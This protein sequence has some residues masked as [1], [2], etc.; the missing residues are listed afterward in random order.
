MKIFFDT[1]VYIAEALLGETAELLIQ[2]TIDAGWRISVSTY[3][4]DEF[5]RVA[6][7][8]LGFRRRFAILSRR[9]MV[10]RA[11]LI[12][13]PASRHA[14]PDDP[15]DSPILQAALAAGSDYLV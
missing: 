1:N 15:K 5:E 6:I 2:R 11:R 8:Q 12:E 9:R 14:V 13:P 3:L 4:L 7:K 10:R